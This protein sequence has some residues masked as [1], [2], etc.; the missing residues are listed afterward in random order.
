MAQRCQPE[1]CGDIDQSTRESRY[2]LE[3]QDTLSLSDSLRLVSGMNYATTAPTPRPT[4]TAPST[5]PPGA[6]SAS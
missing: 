6:C 5:T 4:S 3:I 1:V 2:D